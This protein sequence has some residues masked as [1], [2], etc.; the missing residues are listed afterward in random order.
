[1][2]TVVQPTG[3]TSRSQSSQNAEQQA[4]GAALAGNA[5]RTLLRLLLT[6]LKWV[7]IAALILL[8]SALIC[9]SLLWGPTHWAV[10]LLLAATWVGFL[11]LLV[12]GPSRIGRWRAQSATAL[13]LLMLGLVTVAVSQLSA[14]TPAIVNPQGKQLPGSIATLEK[15]RLGGNEQWL[16]IRGESTES[17]ILLFL[18]GGPGGSQ[19]ASLRYSLG[20]AG[21]EDH[22][23]V[24]NWEQPGS[25]KSFESVDR[26]KMTPERYVSDGHELVLYLLQ[27][28][29]G[30]KVYLMGESWGSA[31]GIMMVQRDPQLFN[32]FVGTG[33][34]VDFTQC[35]LLCYDFALRW[36]QERGDTGQV[37][38]LKNQGPPPYYGNDVAWKEAAYLLDTFSY[39]NQNPAIYERGNTFKD[40]LSPEYGLYDKINWLRGPLDTLNYVYPQL[41]GV[42]FRK[43]ATRLEVPIYFLIGRHDINAPVSLTEEYYN[44]L[45]APHKEIVWF[46]HSGHTPWV[47]EPE[48]F[49]DVVVNKVLEETR[50]ER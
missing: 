10:S 15:I 26:A 44:L 42:D 16:S 14:Y 38:K 30:Q 13:G 24:V 21:L 39:M 48:Q 41:W 45:Q 40:L 6:F 9:I 3:R 23:I 22:F 31:L 19:L 32:A 33:Q 49:V 34:M 37:E 50:A 17:P 35:D 2:N 1:M 11:A 4:S 25:G 20:E 28:F 29:N 27:R 7:A 43:Q 12:L 18:A 5:L 46:E 36:A 8:S 47:S